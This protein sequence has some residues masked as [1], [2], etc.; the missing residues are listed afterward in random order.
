MF[1]RPLWVKLTG[2]LLLLPLLFVTTPFSAAETTVSYPL[3]AIASSG[4][5]TIGNEAAS[6]GTTVFAGDRVTSKDPVLIH[7]N[8]GSRIEMTKA[9]ANF[10]RQGRALVVQVDKGLLRFNFNKGEQVQIDAGEYRFTTV[11]EIRNSG[12]LGLNHRGQIAMNIVDGAFNVLNTATGRQT[13]VT[14]NS[15]FAVMDQ[16]GQGSVTRN[17]PLLSDRS[18]TLAPDELKGKCV[19]A[20]SEAYAILGNSE[21]EITINGKWDLRTGNYSYK[22][23]ECTEETMI[24]AGASEKAAKEA[25]VAAVIGVSPVTEISHTVR[26][27]A[28]IAGVGAGIGIPLAAKMLKEE[29]SP[30][31]R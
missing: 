20:G 7:F 8:S 31:S 15:P 14:A 13:E 25:V 22:V 27:A 9:T 26:N 5:A 19:V 12:E 16:G 4:H 29:K 28:I 3:G 23:V 10:A 2:S 24:R 1:C 6:T 21:S 17:N 11:S 18:L 30:S